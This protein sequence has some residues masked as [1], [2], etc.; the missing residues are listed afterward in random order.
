[1]RGVRDRLTVFAVLFVAGV[2][3]LVGVVLLGRA[4]WVAW[5]SPD[6]KLGE[7][8]N[9]GYAAGARE[10]GRRT[11]RDVIAECQTLQAR[12][13]KRPRT[14]ETAWWLG[15]ESGLCWWL[16]KEEQHD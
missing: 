13:P 8:Y 11:A 7:L 4:A 15:Y 12:Y 2:I 9:A 5:Q 16:D 6:P 3:L 14:P 10:L 1:M